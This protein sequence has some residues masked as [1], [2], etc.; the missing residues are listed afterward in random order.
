MEVTVHV[1]INASAVGATHNAGLRSDSMAAKT[2]SD[3]SYREALKQLGDP[4]N[5]PY[6]QAKLHDLTSG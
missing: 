5:A 3:G 4:C 1:I 2:P 6:T